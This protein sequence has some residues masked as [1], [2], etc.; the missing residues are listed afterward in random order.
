MS[1]ECAKQ[2]AL[3]ENE[4]KTLKTALVLNTLMFVVGIAAGVW[5]QS[6]GLLADALDM[7]A[8]AMAYA[9]GLLAIGRGASFKTKV[10]KLS[11]ALLLLLGLAI[12]VEVARRWQYGS[13][14]QGLLMMAFS[15]LSLAVNVY[16]L[17]SLAQ[18]RR[19]EVHLRSTWIFTKVDV[20]ANIAVFVSGLVVHFTG[21]Q[22]ADLVIGLLIGCYV[23]KEAIEI[24]KEAAERTAA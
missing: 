6:T 22:L 20:I 12:I 3:S 9:L 11:G 21:L 8:D 5:A 17:R 23:V 2:T 18:F 10:A 14:P 7:L 15:L 13:E 19:G 24:L 1:C 16:V 4:R